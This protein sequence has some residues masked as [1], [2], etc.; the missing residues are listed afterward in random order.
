MPAKYKDYPIYTYDEPAIYN[1]FIGGINTDPSNEHLM[2]NEMRD[3]VNMHYN[4]GALVKRPGFKEISKFTY[5][6]AELSNIQGVFLYEHKNTYI[7]V[8]SNGRLYSGLYSEGTIELSSLPIDIKMYQSTS[9]DGENY[10]PYAYNPL[11]A[12]IGLATYSTETYDSLTP[13]QQELADSTGYIFTLMHID[14]ITGQ[15]EEVLRHL[16]FQKTRKVEAATYNNAL[17]I[18]TGTRFIE[19]YEEVSGS[20]YILKA[21]PIAPYLLNNSEYVNIGEN[22]LSPYP[23]YCRETKYGRPTTSL[24]TIL[25]NEDITHSDGLYRYVFP[26][27]YAFTS[28]TTVLMS[29]PEL[30]IYEKYLLYGTFAAGDSITYNPVGPVWT[31][32]PASGGSGSTFEPSGTGPFPD[33]TVSLIKHRKYVLE[34]IMTFADGESY[35]TYCFKWE[36]EYNGMWYTLI[37]Y[38]DNY[39]SRG[40]KRNDVYKIEVY[41]AHRHRYRMSC[42]REFE[43]TAASTLADKYILG[44]VTMYI[45]GSNN[46]AIRQADVDALKAYVQDPV[47]NPLSE[48][49][50]VLADVNRDGKIDTADYILLQ[51]VVNGTHKIDVASPK[52]LLKETQLIY[53]V[54]G[55]KEAV[56]DSTPSGT[57]WVENK[58]D[59][60]FFGRAESLLYVVN[61]T[62][63]DTFNIIHSCTKILADGNKF[64]LYGDSYNTGSWYKTI[65]ANPTYITT[66]GGL[67]FKT[68][69]NEALI[70]VV[71]F[72]GALVVFANS[73]NTGGSIHHVVGNGDDYADDYY[74]PYRRS[75]INTAISC[76]CPDSVQVCENILL[77]KSN[78]TVYY[79]SPS[80]T[81]INNDFVFVHS[82]NDRVKHK[83]KQVNIPWG[84]DSCISEITE[85][86]YGLIWKPLY[87]GEGS[88]VRP[89]TRIKLY[90][91]YQ[92]TIENKYYFPWLRDVSPCFNAS[93]IVYIKG[94]PIYI[95]SNRLLRQE[96]YKDIDEEYS[97]AIR[98]KGVDLGYPKMYK[99]IQ[100]ILLEYHRE[101]SSGVE[102]TVTTKNE[103]GHI[104]VDPTNN[105]RSLGDL[106]A[107]TE[108]VVAHDGLTRLDYTIMDSKVINPS[109][110]FPCLIAETLIEAKN[111]GRFSLSCITYNYTTIETPDS[112]P[113]DLY[114]KIIRKELLQ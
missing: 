60:A 31:F 78:D 11:D 53:R 17:F 7:V 24:T 32:V 21:R 67:S 1:D 13:E 25:V 90:Y 68:T 114:S 63:N 110:K 80:S 62:T 58:I 100:N 40:N 10:F 105:R 43:Y 47:T 45:D 46:Q 112:T 76:T 72:G 8:A 66:R 88:L 73:D 77:F 89:G 87:D 42:A 61:L 23:E 106:G 48:T 44:N 75:T 28:S 19:V 37:S 30:N 9:P 79:L 103:A 107:F 93:S 111:I 38:A 59:G 36:K 86:Y 18:T 3:C 109:F 92:Q 91:K 99:L 6:G 15:T 97:C 52:A 113:Y 71:P 101:Q 27:E 82:I 102:I 94:K 35:D 65:V 16:I 22:Y 41:D 83:N 33:L 69:K 56:Y 5:F 34:P 49:A 29:I 12:T 2:P 104:L 4:S 39:D 85:D 84:D 26:E 98:L 51:R 50:R 55:I 20:T 64:L 108:G 14:Y 54:H 95:S 81:E 70:K 74:S 96:E 57:D